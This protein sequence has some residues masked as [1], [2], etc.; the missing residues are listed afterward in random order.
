MRVFIIS[1]F[2]IVFCFSSCGK[3]SEESCATC[4]CG[5]E[6]HPAWLKDEIVRIESKSKSHRP[7]TIKKCSAFGDDIVLVM[8][9]V[10][11]CLVDAFMFFDCRGN[12]YD[13]TSDD[14]KLLMDNYDKFVL[15]WRN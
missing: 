12:R 3:K 1:L 13:P 4:I 9:E 14:Y 2:M 11:S 8:D 7:I 15:I 6:N 5:S 10:N